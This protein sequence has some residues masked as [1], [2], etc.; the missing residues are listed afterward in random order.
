MSSCTE[1]VNTILPVAADSS[2][3]GPGART[4]ARAPAR[5]KMLPSGDVEHG[6]PVAQAHILD[7]ARPLDPGVGHQDVH[8]TGAAIMA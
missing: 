3:T 4:R 1:L 8:R 6:L 2:A 5:S 7:R